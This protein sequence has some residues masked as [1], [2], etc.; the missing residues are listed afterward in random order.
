MFGH[1]P[2]KVDIVVTKL[3]P[4]NKIQMNAI[5]NFIVLRAIGVLI[6]ECAAEEMDIAVEN[7]RVRRVLI[8]E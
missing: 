5:S 2:I 1:I 4:G 8:P 7:E 6:C 3:S